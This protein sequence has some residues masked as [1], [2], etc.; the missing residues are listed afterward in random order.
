[1]QDNPLYILI[2][3]TLTAQLAD[4]GLAGLVI[5]K[6][7]QD[8]RQGV[9]PLTGAYLI[10][11][12]DHFD[13][14]PEEDFVWDSVNGVEVRTQT[15]VVESTFQLNGLAIQTPGNLTQL[16]ASDT[17]NLL[18]GLLKTPDT[19]AALQASGVGLV[20]L[21]QS[22]NPFFL[23]DKDRYEA[24]ASFDFVLTH[25]QVLTKSVPYSDTVT[26]TLLPVQ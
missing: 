24:N 25:K 12:F 17:A 15:Q 10:K 3:S 7:N 26:L 6:A 21:T 13:G 5:A 16:T 2:I 20:S 4:V 19:M 23:D 22:R 14:M 18:A 1:M 11:L 8:I 9:E